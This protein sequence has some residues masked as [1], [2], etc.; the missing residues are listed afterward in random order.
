MGERTFFL[1]SYEGLREDLGRTII[2]VVPDDN[3]RLGI[4]P[5]GTVP[6]SPVIQPYLNLYP[7]ANRDARPGD[8]VAEHAFKFQQPT[9]QDFFTVRL[10]H[11]F[12]DA[13]T[14]YVRYILDDASVQRPITFPQFALDESS[15]NHYLAVEQQSLF[16]GSWLNQFRF[17]F[18]RTKFDSQDIELTSIDPNLSFIPGNTFGTLV[19]GGL[20]NMGITTFGPFNTP[21]QK[22]FQISDTVTYYTGRHSLKFGANFQ[23]FQIDETNSLADNGAWNFFSLQN[24][25]QNQPFAFLA[26]QPDSDISAEYRQ[27]LLGIWA[28]DDIKLGSN[29]VLNLGVRFEKNSVPTDAGDRFANRKGAESRKGR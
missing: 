10:D 19:V 9:N 14:F 13:N 6:V 2:S 29:F 15:T 16:S 3:A 24:F 22:M 26:L 1:L 20:T 5:T 28:E 21:T 11:R 25:L 17:G 12:S 7:R 27:W 4:L 23:R 18:T 8:G